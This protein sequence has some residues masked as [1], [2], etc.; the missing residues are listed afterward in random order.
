MCIKGHESFRAVCL[1]RWV[2]LD[3]DLTI[4]A[5]V[6]QKQP[7]D[8]RTHNVVYTSITY[9]HTDDIVWILQN[10]AVEHIP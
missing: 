5:V 1:V 2:L 4:S 3:S 10:G 8:L 9:M 6:S 7:M